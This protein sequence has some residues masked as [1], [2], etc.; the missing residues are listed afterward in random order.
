MVPFAE[1]TGARTLDNGLTS[2]QWNKLTP[3]EQYRLNDGQLRG[4]IRDGDLFRDIGPDGRVRA[5]D[6]RK[7]EMLRLQERGVPVEAVSPEEVAR[8]LGGR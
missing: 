6:L 4:R 8:V 1:K 3:K 5:L 2:A 7:A